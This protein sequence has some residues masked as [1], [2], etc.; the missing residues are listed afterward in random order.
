MASPRHKPTLN[1]EMLAGV[2]AFSQLRLALDD[3][4]QARYEVARPLL[5]GQPLSA[6]ERARQTHTH[7]QTVRSY[8]RRF[9][10]E[11]MRGLFQS[12]LFDAQPDVV[13]RCGMTSEAVRLEVLRLKTLYPPLHLREIANILYATLGARVDYKTVQRILQRHPVATQQRLPLARFRD[14]TDPYAA[15][16][17]VVKLYYQGWTFAASA[18]IWVCRANTF[19]ICCIALKPN[20][21]PD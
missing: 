18:A 6:A 12:G 8:V 14:A 19:T 16:V 4:V 7:A 1:A 21:S 9:Q 15:R 20:T 5:L 17:E 11:G 3:P 13:P 10:R 2:E